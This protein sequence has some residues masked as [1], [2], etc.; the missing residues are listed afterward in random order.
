MRLW[1]VGLAMAGLTMWGCQQEA[2]VLPPPAEGGSGLAGGELSVS[3]QLANDVSPLQPGELVKRGVLRGRVRS[4]G[5]SSFILDDQE[6][7]R[8]YVHLSIQTDVMA[9][10]RPASA[11]KLETGTPLQLWFVNQNDRLVAT[12]IEVMPKEQQANGAGATPSSPAP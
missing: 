10:G 12:R 9:E 6:N 4:V 1:V 8:F 7:R 2:T 5:P 11:L 3:E